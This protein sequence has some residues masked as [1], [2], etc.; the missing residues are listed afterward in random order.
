MH[1]IILFILIKLEIITRN[2]RNLTNINTIVC[3][4]FQCMPVN[5]IS[6]GSFVYSALAASQVQTKPFN[7]FSSAGA[8]NISHCELCSAFN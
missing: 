2:Y 1:L 5:S 4:K 6:I 8:Q 3:N 7:C